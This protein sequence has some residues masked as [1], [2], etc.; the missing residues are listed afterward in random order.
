MLHTGKPLEDTDVL[1]RFPRG[2]FTE[3]EQA[4]DPLEQA[5]RAARLDQPAESLVQPADPG[6][7]L[8]TALP[9]PGAAS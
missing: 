8:P 6:G 9:T 4:A 1:R 5:F 2:G 7:E 3:I